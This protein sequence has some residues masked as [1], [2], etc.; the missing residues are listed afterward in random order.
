[1]SVI[2]EKFHVWCGLKLC[3]VV[4]SSVSSVQVLKCTFALWEAGS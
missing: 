3:R 4:L 2:H 1:M